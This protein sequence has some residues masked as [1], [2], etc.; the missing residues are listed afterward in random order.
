MCCRRRLR[1]FV[2]LQMSR[3]CFHSCAAT[4]AAP[5]SCRTKGAR[6]RRGT[7]GSLGISPFSEIQARTWARTTPVLVVAFPAAPSDPPKSS[8]QNLCMGTFD[9]LPSLRITCRRNWKNQTA[10][11][12]RLH[13][14][15]I[16]LEAPSN[17]SLRPPSCLRVCDPRV[18][19]IDAF[20]PCWQ[21]HCCI[22]SERNRMYC[23]EGL[24]SSSSPEDGGEACC[25]A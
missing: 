19:T 5:P 21:G 8:P 13:V 2:L 7:R 6:R 10:K 18:A 1:N 25:C 15:E 20:A 23:L 12:P 24:R 3:S 16:D 22:S 9:R 14:P 11:P 17:R 4:C